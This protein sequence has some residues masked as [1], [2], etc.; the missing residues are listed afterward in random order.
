MS[1]TQDNYGSHVQYSAKRCYCVTKPPFSTVFSNVAMTCISA[2]ILPNI[3]KLFISKL[4]LLHMYQ[5]LCYLK[6]CFAL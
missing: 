5:I 2:T 6:M 3:S 4:L 1:E